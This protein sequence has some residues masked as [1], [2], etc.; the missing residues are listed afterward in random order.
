VVEIFGN[1]VGDGLCGNCV[2]MVKQEH[3]NLKNRVPISIFIFFTSEIQEF[4]LNRNNIFLIFKSHSL[5]KK[6]QT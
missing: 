6:F 5:K 3:T 2:T 1:L 4:G